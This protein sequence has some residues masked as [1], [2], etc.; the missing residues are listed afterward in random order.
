MDIRDAT[1]ADLEAVNA[2]Y[3]H[4]V[5]SSI[6]TFDTAPMTMEERSAWLDERRREGRLVIVPRHPD[7][8]AEALRSLA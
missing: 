7:R 6:S 1:E 3:N 8:L 2:I 4:E 5:E